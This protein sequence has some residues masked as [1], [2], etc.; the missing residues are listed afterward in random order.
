MVPP[1]APAERTPLPR[2]AAA[3]LRALLPHAER[4][5]VL[6]DLAE[7]YG[8]RASEAGRWR[9]GAWV[10]RQVL[11]SV[12]SLLRRSWWRGW[13]GFEPQANR[14]RPGGPMLESWI[15]DVRYATR[16]LRS[17]PTYTLLAVLTLALGVGGTAAIYSI[18]RGLLVDPLPYRNEQEV[19]VFWSPFD[20]TEQEFLY[21]RP[22]F[23]GFSQVAAYRTEDLTLQLG[24][25]PARL[26]PAIASSFEL[27][28]VLGTQPMLGRGFRDGDDRVGAEPVVVISH[29]LW[30]ELGGEASVVGRRL[31]LDGAER[32]VVGVMP[33]GFW[34]PDPTIRAWV[35]TPLREESQSGNYAFIGRV[36]PGQRI[37]STGAALSRLVAR[38]DERY[39]YPAQWDKTKNATLTPVRE[40]LVGS[41][42]PALLATLVAMGLILLIACANVATLMLGQVDS[43]ASELAVRSALGADRRRLT[44]QLV[45]EALALGLAAGAV[46]ALLAAGAFRFL[47][48]ALPLGAWAESATLRWSVFLTAMAIAVAAA[49]L[50]ALAP[51]VSLWRGDLRGALTRARTSG[52]GGRGG[53]LESGLVVAEVALAVLMAAGAALLIRSVS[54][55]YDIDPGVNTS[56][57]AVLHIATGGGATAAQR[58]VILKELTREIGALPGVRSVAAAQRLP[59]SGGG[60]N[61][62]I[63][64]EGKP[65]LATTT[66][67]F[68]VVSPGYLE[69]IGMKLRSG[70]TL[71]ESDG[72]SSERVVVINQALADKYF[73]G[74]DPIGRQIGAGFEGWER[75]VGVVGTAA[76][77][78][79]TDE[80]T[81]ARYMLYEQIPYV[82]DEHS[83]VI[84][85]QQGRDP[86]ALL[87]AAR[88]TVERVAPSVAV[89]EATTMSSIFAR[90][91][92]PA[93]QV[94]ALLTLLT[95]LALVLGA[96]GV[97]GV[98]TH[99]VNRRKRDWGIR[100]ALGQAPSHV[101]GQVVGRGARLVVAGI[102]V[103]LVAAVALARL[104]ASLLYGVGTT[105]AAS[106]AVATAMLLVVGLIAAWVPGYRASRTD[107]ALVLREQ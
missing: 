70:R 101:V 62:G 32:T 40:F 63:D 79:L 20:W 25:A 3:L 48:G 93:R 44:Q 13:S 75:I 80:P 64:I 56:E 53:G 107:P 88:R 98:I 36:A 66:T 35:P 4:D 67:A 55:L 50:I 7:E 58:R 100:I 90:A 24:D 2:P 11:S 95:A 85:A 41:L 42:R 65:E 16:R 52:I 21:L 82:P 92:G 45:A 5:E 74:E 37:E 9:A 31:R 59:L 8:A 43:R 96:V 68:R 33:R 10:W 22:D 78:R 47:V 23:A 26:V 77:T 102:V 19:A 104:L 54:K 17:R 29:G 57:V 14:T 30:Q 39:D 84:R 61:W 105:D 94:M 34:F 6:G 91:V 97:Y 89:Q 12:P 60:D 83:L 38:L 1:A 73:A 28:G 18:V 46:G 81:P 15:M 87:D 76:E 72:P 86:A 27:F 49:L 103:G 51:V 69:T 106:L 71:A 99:F